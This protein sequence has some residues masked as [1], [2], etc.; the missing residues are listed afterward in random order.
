MQTLA[1]DKASDEENSH[2][3][4]HQHRIAPLIQARSMWKE[5]PER[6]LPGHDASSNV[7]HDEAG[8]IDCYDTVSA[9]PTRHKM[10]RIGYEKQRRTLQYRCPAR[11][12]GF[13]CPSD[14][15]C[16]GRR[17]YGKTVRVKC[18]L[19][20]RRFPAMPRATLEFERRYNGCTAVERVNARTQVDWDADD[21]NVSG[22][23]PRPPGD[24]HADARGGGPWA[25]D[26]RT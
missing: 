21:G 9:A 22:S 23:L 17:S 1:C 8:T 19:D 14:K 13:A 6:K 26:A 5:E 3:W 11:H 7:V 12:E 18:E 4:L 15:P 24:D 25:G 10:S 16:N 2:E 20:L